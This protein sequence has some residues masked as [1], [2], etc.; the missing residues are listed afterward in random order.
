VD[1]LEAELVLCGPS[2]PYGGVE[3]VEVNSAV[4]YGGAH[5]A[6]RS[7]AAAADD[8]LRRD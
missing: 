3:A 1:V 7:A 4:P 2:H 6:E 5:R 8:G